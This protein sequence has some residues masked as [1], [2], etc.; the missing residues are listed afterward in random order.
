MRGSR[1]EREWQEWAFLF[2]FMII[3]SAEGIAV[4]I[5]GP[6]AMGTY[7]FLFFCGGPQGLG[8]SAFP[9]P[10]RRVAEVRRRILSSMCM[11]VSVPCFIC[12]LNSIVL[13]VLGGQE[14]D[15]VSS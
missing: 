2:F 8:E 12:P 6:R 5:N 3:I 9:F 15:K 1:G 14:V 4:V 10:R 13:H 7:L 11:M